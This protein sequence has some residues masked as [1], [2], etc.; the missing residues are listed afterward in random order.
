[1]DYVLYVLIVFFVAEIL[2]AFVFYPMKNGK[3]FYALMSGREGNEKILNM[4]MSWGFA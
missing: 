1:M 2:L 4:I 3:N